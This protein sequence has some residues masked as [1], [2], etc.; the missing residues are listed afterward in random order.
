M[1]EQSATGTSAP[2]PEVVARYAAYLYAKTH[3]TAEITVN[4]DHAQAQVAADDKALVLVFR[5][6]A[7]DEWSL[8]S[9][10]VQRGAQTATFV[11][12]QVAEATAAFL[13]EEPLTSAFPSRKGQTC[14]LTNT[15]GAARPTRSRPV[16][17]FSAC[18]ASCPPARSSR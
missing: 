8:R 7:K 11:R 9:A 17:P 12:R 14:L 13:G 2:V 4:S 16:A 1:T 15:P 6:R 5:C 10:E 18:V 3:L